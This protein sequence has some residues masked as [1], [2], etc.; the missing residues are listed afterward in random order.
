MDS[1]IEPACL[2]DVEEEEKVVEGDAGVVVEVEAGVETRGE[3]RAAKFVDQG[4]KVVEV[5]AAAAVEVARHRAVHLRPY[6]DHESAGTT[7]AEDVGRRQPNRCRPGEIP[8]RRYRQ[9]S[10]IVDDGADAAESL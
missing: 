4:E 2:V 1:A 9:A 5:D 6:F 7:G 10:Y 8:Y 3:D